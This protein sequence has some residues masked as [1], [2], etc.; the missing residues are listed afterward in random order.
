LGEDLLFFPADEDEGAVALF[1]DFA[2]GFGA[3]VDVCVCVGG[4]E[5]VKVCELMNGKGETWFVY[6]CV[7]VDVSVAINVWKGEAWLVYK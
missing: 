6:L 1:E 7:D 3:Y 2:G 5:C 4:G